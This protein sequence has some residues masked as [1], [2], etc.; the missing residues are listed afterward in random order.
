METKRYTVIY[1]HRYG[2]KTYVFDT[3][4]ADMNSPE[5]L[6]ALAKAYEIDFEPDIESIVINELEDY[7]IEYIR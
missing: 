5:F 1:S 7:S 3:N 2:V 4:R 6:D